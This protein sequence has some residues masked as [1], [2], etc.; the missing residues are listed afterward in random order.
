MRAVIGLFV[1]TRIG[2]LATI[3]AATVSVPPSAVAARNSDIPLLN[4]LAQW[5]GGAYL[6]LAQHGYSA[7][8]ANYASY[9][10]LYPLLM[11][12]GGTLLGGSTDA[13][14]IVGVLIANLA[15]L[16]ALAGLLR[17]G[18][19]QRATLIAA[20][21]Y[22]LVF[23]TT[24]FL[25]AVYADAL[26]L[27]LII[28]SAVAAERAAW[29]RAGAL[30]AAAA[31]TRPFG[32]V[33]VIPLAVAVWQA[34]ARSSR[35]LMAIALTPA[36]FVAFVVYLYALTGDPL[37]VVH[38]YS[39]GFTPRQP[40]QSLTDLFDPAVYGFP[41]LIGGAFVITVALVVLSWRRTTPPLAAYA[42][43]MLLVITLAGSLASSMRYELS[44][45]PMFIALAAAVRRPV[46]RAAWVI[47]SA[48]L[49]AL[50]AAMFA[51]GY[52]VG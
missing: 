41:W 18:S 19:Q 3:L 34:R 15:T 23:P 20:A 51:L 26:F 40:L 7:E 12:L 11:K 25:S 5:D 27:M 42:T 35:A 32:A 45:F 8:N 2:L 6:Y 31:L 22:I 37:A 21:G 24:I 36:A 9:F 33:A 1:M 47:G 13:Y 44:L 48:L 39:S 46:M 52:W 16:A 29:W 14:L 17:L 49:A 38:A 43:A 50:F 30:A 4:A 28:G 10:P